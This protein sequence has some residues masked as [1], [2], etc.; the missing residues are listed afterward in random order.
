MMTLQMVVERYSALA[1]LPGIPVALEQFGLSPEETGKLFNALDEDYQISRHLH[2][3]KAKCR[4][5]QI[6]GEEVTHVV[7][8]AAISSL[9]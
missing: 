6:S 9:L 1:S 7:L 2:F 5:Y 8:D 4:A 3:S